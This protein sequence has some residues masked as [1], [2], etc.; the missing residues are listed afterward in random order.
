MRKLS[1]KSTGAALPQGVLIA[2]SLLVCAAIAVGQLTTVKSIN[3]TSQNRPSTPLAM[4]SEQPIQGLAGYQIIAAND[5]GMHC[6]DLDHRIASIL[7]PFNVMH[8][9]AVR[10]GAKPRILGPTDVELVYSAASNPLD[11]SLSRPA[12]SRIYKTNFWDPNPRNTGRSIAFDAYKPHYPPG[13]LESFALP[14]DQGLPVPDLQRLYLGDHQLSADRQALP[15]A[16]SITP[17]IT[18]PYQANTA[19]RFALYYN[20]FPFFVSFPFGY[21]L[22]GI[23]WFSAEGI[24]MSPFDDSGRGNEYPLL[25]VQARA[26]PGNTLGL[27]PGTLLAT[28]DTVAPVSGEVQCMSCHTS[29]IDGGTGMATD[30]K[31]FTVATRFTDPTF[32][33]V[34]E[35][36][37]LEYAFD[38]N[39]VRLHDVKHGTHLEQN[40]PISCQTC[41]YSPALDLA[42]VG[43]RGPSDADAN[44]RQQKL[45]QTFSRVMHNF[46]GK[47]TN[48]DG[49]TLFPEMPSPLKRTVA[50]R[51]AVLLKSCYTCHPGAETKCFRGAMANAGLA[52]QDCH[53]GLLKVGNDFSRNVSPGNPGA[54][55]VAGD[56]Y[57]NPATPRV[58]WANEPMCQSCHTGDVLSN[59]S[60]SS[61]VVKSPSSFRLVQ[62]YRTSDTNAQPIV[63]RNRRFS[64]NQSGTKQ[65]LYRL[66]E[67]HGGVFCQGC[68]GST[69]AEWPNA[70]A[71]ANDNVAANELQG[72][73][74][75]LI[76]CKTCHGTASFPIS[77]FQRNFDANGWMKGPHGMHPVDD[78]NWNKNHKEVFEDGGTPAGTCQACH[79]ANL[80]GSPLGR[81]AATRTLICA[82]K[83]N[84]GCVETSQ[85]K[86]IVLSKG[87]PVSCNLCHEMPGR[88]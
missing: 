59:L 32:G 48:P 62:A 68:H 18:Q 13:V 74:G 30:G 44:G 63:A 75:T 49:T 72:H 25:R 2:G 53:G 76:E 27:A 69:H 17:F 55:S 58:P 65:V 86:R 33:S 45:H 71:S 11:P 77:A 35:A 47:L 8:A 66:S 46:H 34:P 67:G 52:C 14:A 26:V 3:S 43:P 36:V 70:T 83:N 82:E 42:H 41:H 5:L 54:F 29:A 81:V 28:L 84:R 64:E 38:L 12:P 4:V 78:A 37:S 60:A 9:Q 15:S 10:K 39:V 40:T 80:E 79:G 20:S 24:P 73:A 61:G 23:D 56:Y 6:S 22:P 50:V 87:T 19:Q 16:V 21:T 51:D 88:D 57:T 85:G 31:G 1:G 7:P